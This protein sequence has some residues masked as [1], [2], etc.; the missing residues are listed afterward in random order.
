LFTVQLRLPLLAPFDLGRQESG[1]RSVNISGS[2]YEVEIARHRRA[3]RYVLRVRPDGA[4]RLTVPR[5][6]SIAGGLAFVSRQGAWVE[7]ER[8]RH[9]HRTAPLGQGAQ[10]WYRGRLEIVTIA[11]GW[12]TCGD[13]RIALKTGAEARLVVERHL[14]DRAAT[15]LPARCLELA[16]AHDMTIARV[17]VRNQRSRWGACSSRRV[18][19]LNWRLIQMP[20]SVS[21][22]VILHE[23]MH[24]RQPNHSRRFWREVESVCAWWREAERWLKKNGRE[25]L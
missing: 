24:V 5:G 4:L 3:R 8:L 11:Q 20:P 7:R 2:L 21:D 12:L 10:I 13:N 22:Y 23:L 9:Q 17:S 14:R 16:A 19:T 25:I 1:R 15:E 18:I 6:Q